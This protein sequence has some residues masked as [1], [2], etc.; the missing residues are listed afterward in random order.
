MSHRADMLTS[1]PGQVVG[2]QDRQ[3]ADRLPELRPV[4]TR[5]QLRRLP[6]R[7]PAPRVCAVTDPI[8]VVCAWCRA[9]ITE[10]REPVSHGICPSCEAKHFPKESAH[11]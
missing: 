7:V 11:G 9:T 5:R 1:E 8:K 2:Y 3:P 10:G 6:E 4:A